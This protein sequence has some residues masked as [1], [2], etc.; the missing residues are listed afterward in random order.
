[1]TSYG[2]GKASF[3]FAGG[4]LVSG[5]FSM[6]YVP[7][8]LT[9]TGGNANVN[10]NSYEMLLYGALSGPGGLNK[11]G[12]GSLMLEAANTFSGNTTVAGGT[13][14]LDNANALAQQHARL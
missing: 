13:L 5:N 8:T 4:T 10:T 3:N 14:Y 7:M 9:G 1:M 12:A 2:P 6:V 11:L